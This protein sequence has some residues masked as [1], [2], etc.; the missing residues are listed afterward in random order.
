[1]HLFLS[2]RMLCILLNSHFFTQDCLNSHIYA[3][4][5]HLKTW[6]I[7]RHTPKNMA[8]YEHVPVYQAF[9]IVH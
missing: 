4:N 3:D 2:P 1:M 6:Q 9:P 8:M 7:C 5:K